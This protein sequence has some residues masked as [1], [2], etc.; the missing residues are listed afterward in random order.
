MTMNRRR[1]EN[2]TVYSTET[3]RICPKCGLPIDRC[4]CKKNQ[5][6]SKGDGI[7]RVRLESKGRKG[8]SVT[9][10]TGLLLDGEGLKKL[11][12]ELKTMCGAG[13]AVKDGVI[14]I[15]GDHTAIVMAELKKRGF[16]AKRA[17]G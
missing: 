9:T 4:T 5:L 3:G 17:G 15:Q 6:A 7:V 14:E 13:G 10:I 2:R 12:G 11:A 1:D 16:T 8:K